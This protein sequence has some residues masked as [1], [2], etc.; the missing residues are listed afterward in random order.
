[1]TAMIL[2]FPAVNTFQTPFATMNPERR[3]PL[4]WKNKKT[5]MSAVF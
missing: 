4:G 5:V 2:S 1:M 3:Q